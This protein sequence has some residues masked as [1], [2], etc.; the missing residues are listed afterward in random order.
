MLE[1]T[2]IAEGHD[3]I[4]AIILETVVGAN[5]VIIYPEG[6]LQ[7]VRDLCDKY[8]IFMICD[9]VMAGFGRTGEWFAVQN[10]GVSPDMITFAKGVN[11]G[12]VQLGGVIMNEKVASHFDENVLGCGL[13]YQGHPLAC[14]AGYA[15]MDYFEDR[16]S[17]RL[18]SS[19]EWISYAVF[20]LK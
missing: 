10:W 20:G 4:A 2:I 16:K 17:T 12:Y 19:H 14:A 6:Y 1:K 7:G 11:S 8:G 13:T 18:N 15:S 3:K 5:G 9:E